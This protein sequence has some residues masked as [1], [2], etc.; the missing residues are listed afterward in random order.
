MVK[1]KRPRWIDSLKKVHG[2]SWVWAAVLR[3]QFVADKM[4]TRAKRPVST[5]A[6]HGLPPDDARCQA[7]TLAGKRCRRWRKKVAKVCPLHGP[8][9]IPAAPW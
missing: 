4:T 7:A 5:N 8:A 6:A 2:G 1:K 3:F 9:H